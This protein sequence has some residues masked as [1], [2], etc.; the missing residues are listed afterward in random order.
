M[1]YA[2]WIED[3]AVSRN[4]N[5]NLQHD[6]AWKLFEHALTK[7]Y[8]IKLSECTVVRNRWGR[9]SLKEYPDIHFSIS[10][11]KSMAVCIVSDNEVG[12]DIETVGRVCSDKVWRRML[13][14]EEYICLTGMSDEKERDREFLKYWTLKES[15]GKAIGTGLSYDYKSIS[16]NISDGEI[17][18]NVPD[19]RL[20]QT[21]VKKNYEEVII[22][23][24]KKQ[25]TDYTESIE[26]VNLTGGEAYET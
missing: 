15:Y 20:W 16:F 10:H 5:S 8:G 14:D 21:V 4:A 6:M 3:D 7:E 2:V 9:P 26:W 24:C 22:S 13:S 17:V 25:I 11:N 23:V 19:Y 1:I 12:I 18:C